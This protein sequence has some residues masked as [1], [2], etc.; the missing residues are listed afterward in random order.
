[1]KRGWCPGVHEP[2][3]SGDGLLI[4]VKPFGGRLSAGMLRT[5]AMVAAECGNGTVELTGRGNIQLRGL[6]AATAKLASDA[7]VDA[8]LADPDPVR[9]ARRNVIAVPPCDD[10]LVAAIEALLAETPGLAPKFCVAVGNARADIQVVG[11]RV[12]PLSRIAGEGRGEGEESAP[13]P[14]GLLLGLPFGQSDA[15]ALL[16]LAELIAHQPSWSAKAD[17]PRL[18]GDRAKESRGSSAF[19]EDDVDR[20]IMRTTPWRSF[21]LEGTHDPAPFAEAGFITDPDDPR[22]AISA[23]AGAPGCASASVPTRADAAFLAARGIRGIHVSGCAKGCAHPKAATTL[24]GS[25]GRYGFVRH[26]RAGDRPAI[27]GLTIAQ[28]AELLA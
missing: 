6:T 28:A 21:Y 3:P 4:R 1:M 8:G 24:V 12:I 2:M 22:R 15:A 17:H 19:A 7:L 13:L 14:P 20:L 10:T 16:R 25:G 26:G 11:S 18:P 9:E 23:C 27:T 5:L